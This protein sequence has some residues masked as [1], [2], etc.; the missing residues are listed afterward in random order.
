[1][2]PSLMDYPTADGSTYWPKGYVEGGTSATTAGKPSRIVL[3]PWR[4]LIYRNVDTPFTY[5]DGGAIF[6][7]MP[8]NV[9][10]FD[11]RAPRIIGDWM[12]SIPATRINPGPREDLMA[13]TGNG[14][15]DLSP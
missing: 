8:M 11:C 9:P 10:G 15:A 4:S 12:V 2:T 13:W 7:H 3:A 1:I 6:P 14:G 5:S